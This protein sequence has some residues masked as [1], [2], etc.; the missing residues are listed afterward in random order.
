MKVIALMPMKGESERVPNKNMRDFNGQPLC[1]VMLDKL[2]ASD[3][4]DQVIINT[5]SDLIKN[6]IESRYD[7]VE[8]V[9][10]PLE[11]RG[12]DVSMNKI[13]DYYIS[14]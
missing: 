14:Q 2:M 8:I 5:D 9:E 6:F 13:I 7:K 12:H 1:S 10:R 4:I 3:L 11:L